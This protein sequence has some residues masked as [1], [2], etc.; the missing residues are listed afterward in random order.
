MSDYET[1]VMLV[2]DLIDALQECDPHAVV[3]NANGRVRGYVVTA[4]EG[5]ACSKL[6]P[7][8]APQW[9]RFHPDGEAHS[10][11]ARPAVLLR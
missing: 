2:A 3:L 11:S 9:R 10:D 4:V 8:I 1:R 5:G 7:G 6:S